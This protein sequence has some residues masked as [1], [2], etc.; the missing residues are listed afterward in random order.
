MYG[1]RRTASTIGRM[2]QRLVSGT[3][4]HGSST[5]KARMYAM[6]IAVPGTARMSVLSPSS[7][8]RPG[9]RVRARIHATG[10]PIAMHSTT[11]NPE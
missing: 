8:S 11:A 4:S 6:P 2:I 10:T 5:W 3:A 7:V 1:S 9:S